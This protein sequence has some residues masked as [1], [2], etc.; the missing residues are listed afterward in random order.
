M[1]I[2]EED[3]RTVCS[4]RELEVLQQ[5]DTPTRLRAERVAMEEVASYLRMRYDIDR[6][7][8][9]TGNERNAHLVQLCV[10]V[11]LYYLVQWLPQKMASAHRTEQYERAIEWLKEAG[12]GKVTA[13]LPSAGES[14]NGDGS[15]F[16]CMAGSMPRSQYDW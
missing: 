15:N 14:G 3:Y 6:A 11:T 10:T 16:P 13:S 1:F 5:S 8:A 2:E 12:A 7:Y 9:A 4:P